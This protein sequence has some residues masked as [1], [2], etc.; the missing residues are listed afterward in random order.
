MEVTEVDDAF[1]ARFSALWR[2]YRYTLSIGPAP[3]PLTRGQEWHVGPGLD[4]PSMELTATLF[5]GEQDFSAFCRSLEGH[6][7]VRRVDEAS[8]ETDSHRLHFWIT[9]NA[10]CHQMVRS[11]VGLSYDVGRGF[12]PFDSVAEI[13]ESRDRSRVVTVAPPYGLVLWEVGY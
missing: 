3:D 6:T 5:P 10:F 8:W 1:H 9:A 12:T 13:I 7:N 11:L 2:R 4:L